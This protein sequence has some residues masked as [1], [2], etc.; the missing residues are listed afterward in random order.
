FFTVWYGG[1]GPS[2][3]CLAL[4]TFAAAFFVRPVGGP[5]IEGV[6]G[7]VSLLL[8]L[9]VGGVAIWL[10]ESLRLAWLR[11]EAVAEEAAEQRER[12][13]TTL[14]SI[15]DAV[16]VT[17]DR[18]RVTLLNGVAESLTG[19]P[20]AE[21]FGRPLEEVFVIVNEQTGGPVENP[22]ARV[23]REGVVVG[24]ANHTVLIDRGGTRRP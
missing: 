6:E 2:L 3:L 23:L 1:I 11:A 9:F 12:L 8:F 20:A 16:L 19:W 21:A 18:G 10:S 24:L 14:A 22:V 4:S 7:W 15:G 17:D 5:G 13:R